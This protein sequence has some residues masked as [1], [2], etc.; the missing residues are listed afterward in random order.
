MSVAIAWQVYDMTGNLLYLGLIGLVQFLPVLILVLITGWTADRF[1]R[2]G[3]LALALGVE[4]IGAATLLW[5]ALS[6]FAGVGF[7][8]SSNA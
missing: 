5:F 8:V 6:G 7:S 4:A 3:I 1:S 2:R